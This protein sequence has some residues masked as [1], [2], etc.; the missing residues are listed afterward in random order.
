LDSSTILCPIFHPSPI[1]AYLAAETN[2]HY[3]QNFI[4]SKHGIR[5]GHAAPYGVRGGNEIVASL[6]FSWESPN[7]G[8]TFSFLGDCESDRE[9]DVKSCVSAYAGF[10]LRPTAKLSAEGLEST[11]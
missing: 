1:T 11:F 6:T 7:F 4:V 9:S 2:H 3:L 8:K 5:F 10:C